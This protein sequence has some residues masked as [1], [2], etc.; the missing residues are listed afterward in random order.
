MPRRSTKEEA[1]IL[2]GLALQE[3]EDLP[4]SRQR[5]LTETKLQEALLWLQETP[6][7]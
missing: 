2:I 6:D 7:Q 3:L 1:K 5:A 4:K